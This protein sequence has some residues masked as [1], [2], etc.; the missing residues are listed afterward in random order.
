[1]QLTDFGPGTTLDEEDEEQGGG[2][3]PVSFSTGTVIAVN[4]A[5]AIVPY[6]VFYPDS[7]NNLVITL[8]NFSLAF[9]KCSNPPWDSD[10]TR[11]HTRSFWWLAGS[12]SFSGKHG[13]HAGFRSITTKELLL[14]IRSRI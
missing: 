12:S 5:A 13:G 7:V 10:T 9:F 3:K 1:M 6:G 11:T 8:L 14:F 2:Q 4:E